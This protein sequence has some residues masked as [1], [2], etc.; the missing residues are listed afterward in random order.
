MVGRFLFGEGDGEFPTCSLQRWSSVPLPN[1]FVQTIADAPMRQ[2]VV[3]TAR[4]LKP[5]VS[6]GM[7]QTRRLDQTFGILPVLMTSFQSVATAPPCRR[8]LQ[9]VVCCP[10]IQTPSARRRSSVTKETQKKGKQARKK[11]MALHG[12]SASRNN[13][14]CTF[15][16]NIA[17][18]RGFDQQTSGGRSHHRTSVAPR[19]I[20]FSTALDVPGRLVPVLRAFSVEDPRRVEQQRF[21][22][23]RHTPEKVDRFRVT[24]KTHCGIVVLHLIST[25]PSVSEPVKLHDRGTWWQS[26]K[27]E[28]LLNWRIYTTGFVMLFGSGKIPSVA[29]AVTNSVLLCIKK[30]CLRRILGELLCCARSTSS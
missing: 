21:K 20:D 8:H 4:G 25:L 24:R 30:A 23:R 29:H 11:N 26:W 10:S 13:K 14:T 6:C 2:I 16:R 28:S 18:C 19:G 15:G 7:R 17:V 9:R 1:P 27:M 12:V 5:S 22:R 3:A